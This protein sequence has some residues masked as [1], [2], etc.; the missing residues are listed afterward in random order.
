MT[1]L[2]RGLGAEAKREMGGMGIAVD[3]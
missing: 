2:E 1:D 3:Q